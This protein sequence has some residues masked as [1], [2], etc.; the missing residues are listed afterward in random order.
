MASIARRAALNLARPTSSIAVRTFATPPPSAVAETTTPPTAPGLPTNG[1]GKGK[2]KATTAPKFS[3]PAIFP[4][5]N[6]PYDLP[7]EPVKEEPKQYSEGQRRLVRGLARIMG[8]NTKATT[9]I[10][11]TGRMMKGIVEA[12]ERDRAFWYDGELDLAV[13]HAQRSGGREQHSGSEEFRGRSS[14]STR[15]RADSQNASCRRRIRPSSSC[16]CCTS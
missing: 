11:E 4:A 15:P 9:A 1:N 10:R 3:P 12:V 8:Y 7:K 14:R 6:N 13:C 5:P 2:E 16:T